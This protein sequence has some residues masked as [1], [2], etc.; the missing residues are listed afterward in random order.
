MKYEI[1]NFEELE[2]FALKEAP[3]YETFF[4]DIE[5]DESEEEKEKQKFIDNNEH[6]TVDSRKDCITRVKKRV[7]QI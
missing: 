4:N 5:V 2:S 3:S 6:S 7:Y 1:F